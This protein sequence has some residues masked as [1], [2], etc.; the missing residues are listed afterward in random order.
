[1]CPAVCKSSLIMCFCIS[2]LMQMKNLLGFLLGDWS[3]IWCVLLERQSLLLE[4]IFFLL[5]EWKCARA[6]HCP[7]GLVAGLFWPGWPG[8]AGGTP[9]DWQGS[10]AVTVGFLESSPV[11]SWQVAV[12]PC[13][14]PPLLLVLLV[15]ALEHMKVLVC[16]SE[17][18]SIPVIHF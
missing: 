17:E 3:L 8:R 7:L 10:C 12:G 1:M 6:Q 2:F 5:K 11:L 9:R 4:S 13:L 16:R 18:L 14:V 15:W